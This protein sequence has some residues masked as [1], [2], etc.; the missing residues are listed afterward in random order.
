[1]TLLHGGLP[2]VAAW[3]VKGPGAHALYALVFAILGP[4]ELAI[5][6]FDLVMDLI[7][8]A[9]FV[10]IA[11]L[12][13]RVEAGLLGWV[14]ALGIGIHANAWTSAQ[15]DGW[16][17]VI[18]FWAMALS[19]PSRPSGKALVGACLLVGL[20]TT[21]KPQFALFALLPLYRLWDGT[22]ASNRPSLIFACMFAGALPLMLAIGV[23]VAAG[24]FS[25]LWDVMVTF[26][27]G[28]HLMTQKMPITDILEAG[29]NAFILKR[30][31]AVAPA[32]A[33]PGWIW[34]W[35]RDRNMARMSMLATVVAFVCAAVQ[36]KF[37]DYQLLTYTYTICVPAGFGVIA[38]SEML[39]SGRFVPL[40]K[41]SMRYLAP[42]P[43]L[44][45][46]IVAAG[47][48]RRSTF[49]VQYASGH[50]SEKK[51]IERFISNDFDPYATREAASYIQKSTHSG[52]K[53]LLWGFDAYVYFLSDRPAFS[54]FGY[55]YPMV[56]AGPEY[57]EKAREEFLR[58]LHKNL[59]AVIVIQKGDKNNLMHIP[60][61][62]SF[63]EFSD[64]RKVVY[65]NFYMA[66]QNKNFEVWRQNRTR[67]YQISTY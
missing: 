10:R 14:L 37:Y 20:A 39:Y 29:L 21:I 40:F 31:N 28:S 67:S 35:R 36:L 48:V 24:Q 65:D 16:A 27:L 54:R 38:L 2:Y 30:P 61:D 55:D 62:Q 63:L 44:L 17:A 56:S 32:L 34:L 9:A 50:M 23:F 59:P 49:V 4:S 7:L 42:V 51:Y 3:D 33:I 1:M 64:F 11:M 46:L 26:N 45:P 53:V 8:A 43:Y 13:K 52:E 18:L 58:D 41:T 47:C 66:Y 25:A 15:P 5:R 6:T 57:R 12:A 19:F 60:S 22:E